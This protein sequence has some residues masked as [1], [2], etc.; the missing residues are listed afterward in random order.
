MGRRTTAPAP[1]PRTT[2]AALSAVHCGCAFVLPRHGR[3]CRPC[4]RRVSWDTPRATD[5]RG[6]CACRPTVGA[7]TPCRSAGHGNG[8]PLAAMPAAPTSPPSRRGCPFPPALPASAPPLKIVRPPSGS[9][10]TRPSARA[11]AVA[12]CL[13]CLGA[14]R[15][16][17]VSPPVAPE[18]GASVPLRVDRTFAP[19]APSGYWACSWSSR[20]W[21]CSRPPLTCG[22]LR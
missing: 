14:P 19:S 10:P 16:A 8:K 22:G 2:A 20:A 21:L 11:A 3:R 9:P 1:P 15:A 17:A 5:A 6:G 4:R 12:S 13:P 7:R 18:V